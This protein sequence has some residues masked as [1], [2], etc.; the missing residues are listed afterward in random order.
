MTLPVG[1]PPANNALHYGDCLDWMQR[2]PDNCVDLIYLDP[3]FNSN[4]DYNMLYASDGGGDAQFR[5]FAD[6]WTWDNS[7]SDR[8]D[9]YVNAIGRPAHNAIDGLHRLLGESGMLAYLTYMAERL[10]ECWRLLKPSGSIYLH[11]DPTAS[12]YL[13]IVMDSVFGAAN[14]INEITWK[15]TSAHSRVVRYGPIH[16]VLLFYSRGENWKWNK[17][18]IPYNPDYVDRFYRHVDPGTKRRYRLSDVTSNNPGGRY[19]WKGKPPPGKRYWGYAKE[20]MEE[21]ER[22]GR[23]VYSKKTGYPSYKRYLDEMPGQLLQDVWTDIKPLQANSAER[24]GYPTQKPVELLE[25][26]I[27]ASSH[28]GDIVLDPFCG[29]GTAVDAANRLGR[30]WVGIDISS[31][32]VEL[33]KQRMGDRTIPTYGIPSDLRSAAKMAASDPFGFE[34]WAVNRIPGFLPNVKQVADGGIDGRGRLAVRPDNWNSRLALAQ[35]KGGKHSPIDG[36][37]AFCGVTQERKAAWSCYVTVEPFQTK[38]ARDARRGLGGI[39][40]GAS[41]YER[42]N[43]WSITDYFKDRLPRQPTMANPYTGKPLELQGSLF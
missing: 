43:L 7:A 37:R 40:V 25:R 13:K 36:L 11:C 39:Q 10:G 26:I 31:F 5:A 22:E 2:W 18:Y 23:L 1:Q 14:F 35:V 34:T 19:K 3:P 42:M 29:C 20:K 27:R 38:S 28:N 9:S 41:K 8:L 24:L 12:H 30:R 33:I 15:R 6:T 4:A 17:Q 32:A 21:F 16:D